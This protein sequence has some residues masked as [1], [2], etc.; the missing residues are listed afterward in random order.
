MGYSGGPAPA[1]GDFSHTGGPVSHDL[2]PV[3]PPPLLFVDVNIAPG[4][5]PERIVV[6][7]GQSIT[8]VA[9]D[10]AAKHVL[11]PVLAQRLHALL[12]EVLARQEQLH[13][14]GGVAGGG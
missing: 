1:G 12:R 2:I 6:H 3:S 9:A 4:Q 7:E 14:T 13:D 5:P 8:E 11:T 10:F